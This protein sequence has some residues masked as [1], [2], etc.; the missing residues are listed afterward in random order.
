MAC[1]HESFIMKARPRSRE[2]AD[3]PV[4]STSDL[5]LLPRFLGLPV[6]YSPMAVGIV[7]G[8]AHTLMYANAAFRNLSAR[9]GAL[10]GAVVDRP[11]AE[12]LNP[13]A[14][15][16]LL[17]L[18]E[19]ARREGIP[20]RARLS[21]DQIGVT[22][23]WQC[24]A[25]AASASAD[26]RDHED[27]SDPMVIEVDTASY[28]DRD[29]AKY[30]ELT[31][32]L[33]LSAI[34][35]DAR[36]VEADAARTRAEQAKV[37]QGRFLA[38]VSHEIRTPMQAIIGY[39]RLIE[40]ELRVPLTDHQHE[41]LTGI[42]EGT[43]HVV[44]LLKELTQYSASVGRPTDLLLTNV[45]VEPTLQAAES[46]VAPQA[47]AK[48]VAVEIAPGRRGAAVSANAAKLL[49]VV[50]NLLDNAVK[51]TPSGGTITISWG[52]VAAPDGGSERIAIRVA[53][54]GR[55]IASDELPAVFDPYI[56]VGEHDASGD[57]GV[58]LGLAISRELARGM[59]GELVVT[60]TPGIGSVFTLTLPVA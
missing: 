55:G 48:G 19:K 45:E 23:A 25:W 5:P 10:S 24:V 50:L 42:R 28:S 17:A 33:L 1:V 11:L 49:Q 43:R 59:H 16:S 7:R 18:I 27:R 9:T 44:A 8:A 13:A 3:D 36:A 14:A 51:F 60:S 4:Q 15:Q 31:E 58:G 39:A 26:L 21:A 41:A 38:E 37:A 40:K 54:T 29:E 53:D 34:R 32:L 57:T 6:E 22:G 2:P 52:M 47:Y 46:L 12:S 35:E 56:Q 20:A 30:R